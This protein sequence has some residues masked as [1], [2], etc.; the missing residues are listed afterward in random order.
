MAGEAG[1]WIYQGLSYSEFLCEIFHLKGEGNERG[2]ETRRKKE[3]EEQRGKASLL[4]NRRM[5]KMKPLLISYE[6]ELYLK[7]SSFSAQV[8]FHVA[9]CEP[10]SAFWAIENKLPSCIQPESSQFQE[11]HSLFL[12]WHV[13]VSFHYPIFPHISFYSNIKFLANA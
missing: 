6:T 12:L 9:I 7:S 4:E 10:G 1:W 8:Y 2:R 3:N 13:F 5:R 11:K